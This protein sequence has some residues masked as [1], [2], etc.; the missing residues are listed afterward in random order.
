MDFD[1]PL[2][3]R[4]G[5]RME[6]TPK[7]IKL[8]APLDDALRSL[9][10]LLARADFDPAET[11]RCFKI[12]TT[13]FIMAMLSAPLSSVM[14]DDAPG[15]SVQIHTA[16]RTSVQSLMVGNIDMVITPTNL[17]NAG[18]SSQVENDSVNHEIVLREPLSCLAS[19]NDDEFRAGLTLDQYLQRPH[20]GYV[21]GEGSVTSMEQTYLQHLGLKQNDKLLVSSYAALAPAVAST[22]YLSLVP[23]SMAKAAATLFPVQYAPPPFDAPDM[24][25]SMVWHL[26]EDRSSDMQWLRA[27]VKKC[28]NTGFMPPKLYALGQAKQRRNAA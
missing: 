20:A 15:V 11:E 23:L 6:L 9:E 2:V 24:E 25:W 10:E 8:M 17:L 18:I 5:H 22:G 27:T 21:F 14:A 19:A 16:Q 1:D 28:L 13:D 12:A 4:Q 3:V 7:A 26:R